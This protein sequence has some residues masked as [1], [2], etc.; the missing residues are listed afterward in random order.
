MTLTLVPSHQ[1]LVFQI[2][3]ALVRGPVKGVSSHESRAGGACLF[4]YVRVIL[5][6]PWTPQNSL[7]ASC[8]V[9]WRRRLKRWNVR[10]GK[11]AVLIIALQILHNPR[12]WH[13]RLLRRSHST[14]AKLV[15]LPAVA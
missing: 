11:A 10:T 9:V 15:H 5:A 8:V 14:V 6:F 4:N 1:P 2:E 7:E 13:R 3:Q 12:A